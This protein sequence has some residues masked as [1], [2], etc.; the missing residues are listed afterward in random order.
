MNQNR[1]T[2]ELAPATAA[3]ADPPGAGS[4]GIPPRPAPAC[5]A[6]PA[7]SSPAPGRRRLLDLPED[8]LSRGEAA[9]CACRA[10]AGDG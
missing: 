10:T 7:A 6:A 9:A 1:A 8:P 5:G 4:P 2:D 3:L